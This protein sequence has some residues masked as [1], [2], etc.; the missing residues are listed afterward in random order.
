MDDFWQK[1]QAYSLTFG[2]KLA[3]LRHFLICGKI[4]RRLKMDDFWQKW[5]AYSLTFGPKLAV[6]RHVLNFFL[7]EEKVENG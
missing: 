3:V 1:W 6:L 2:P 7:N 4:W 5:Q